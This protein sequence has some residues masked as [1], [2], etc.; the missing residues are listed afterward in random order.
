MNEGLGMRPLTSTEDVDQ[1]F[2][3]TLGR[4][5]YRLGQWSEVIQGPEWIS[6]RFPVWT[7]LQL[8]TA[9]L[10]QCRIPLRRCTSITASPQSLMTPGQPFLDAGVLSADGQVHWI[11]CAL[12]GCNGYI[13][14][15]ES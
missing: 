4:R 9:A 8:R 5:M 14:G 2:R 7:T 13:R 12:Y 1:G 3:R 11:I 15:Q 6:V 10:T